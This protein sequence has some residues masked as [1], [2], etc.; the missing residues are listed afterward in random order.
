MLPQSGGH[1][2]VKE[3]VHTVQIR[4]LENSL[5]VV[6]LEPV[7]FHSP[8]AVI[9]SANLLYEQEPVPS[10]LEEII[11]FIVQLPR[12]GSIRRDGNRLQQHDRFSQA[13]VNAGTMITLF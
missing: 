4:F 6:H 7:V 3:Q 1:A 8:H 9:S 2:N 12:Y 13:D 10:S 11:Y 5:K